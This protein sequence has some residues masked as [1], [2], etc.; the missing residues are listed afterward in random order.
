MRRKKG[1]ERKAAREGCFSFADS[2]FCRTEY[3]DEAPLA[4]SASFF[5]AA[6][7]GEKAQ[8]KKQ[9][10]RAVFLSPTVA[11]Y[12]KPKN[13]LTVTEGE[14]THSNICSMILILRYLSLRHGKP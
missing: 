3:G 13:I 10:A 2:R 5:P 6:S 1:A 8:S 4:E 11:S 9:P 12:A 7:C 14:I